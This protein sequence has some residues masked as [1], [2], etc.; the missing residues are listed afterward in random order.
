MNAMT[1]NKCFFSLWDFNFL[2]NHHVEVGLFFFVGFCFCNLF[3]DALVPTF[4][5]RESARLTGHRLV[6]DR[7][8]CC[9]A[10]SGSGLLQGFGRVLLLYSHKRVSL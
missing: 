1:Q 5:I 2:I 9:K 10:K 6:D 8:A 3:R 7:E 4:L